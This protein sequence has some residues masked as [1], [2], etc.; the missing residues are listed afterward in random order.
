MAVEKIQSVMPVV[1]KTGVT[2]CPGMAESLARKAIW[3]VEMENQN[4]STSVHCQVLSLRHW[5]GRRWRPSRLTNPESPFADN[6]AH[7]CIIE[8]FPFKLLGP[9]CAGVLKSPIV[10]HFTKECTNGDDS[11]AIPESPNQ[12]TEN[13]DNLRVPDG[14]SGE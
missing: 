10:C 2:R 11:K 7:A 6:D 3:K 13:D 4:I 1:A 12:T 9:L 14:G 8:I 5:Q